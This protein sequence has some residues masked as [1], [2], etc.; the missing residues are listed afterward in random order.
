MGDEKEVDGFAVWSSLIETLKLIKEEFPHICWCFIL[1]DSA[2]CYS[3]AYLA[4]NLAAVGS[5]TGI[6]VK[7][8]Y[9]SESGCGKFCPDANFGVLMK[10]V[11]KV[12]NANLAARNSS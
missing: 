6:Y 9:I 8:H 5:V 12:V 1:S 11:K 2:G 7:A 3:A 4:I 10:H